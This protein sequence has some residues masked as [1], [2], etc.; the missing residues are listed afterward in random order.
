[1]KSCP[2]SAV[3]PQLCRPYGIGNH[4]SEIIMHASYRNPSTTCKN[5][6][7]P[8][9]LKA[10]KEGGVA[11]IVVRIWIR[12]FACSSSVPVVLWIAFPTH[13]Y[14]FLF[15]SGMNKYAYLHIR[16]H[17]KTH[18]THTEMKHSTKCPTICIACCHL[19]FLV[20]GS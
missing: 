2:T 6:Y 12:A 13:I 4:K 17:S 1:M 3:L 8:L 18:T 15:F 9:N 11:D 5:S 10:A 19:N 14:L 7:G 20:S 16:A